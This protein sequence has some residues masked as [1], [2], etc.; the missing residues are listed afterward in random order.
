MMDAK[1]TTTQLDRFVT[2]RGAGCSL[3]VIAA[4]PGL[5]GQVPEEPAQASSAQVRP[6]AGMSA[7]MAATCQAMMH[8]GMM[9]HMMEHMQ[10]GKNSMEMCPMMKHPGSVKH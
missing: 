1:E 9:A 8:H 4:T 6:H 3:L 7:D 10:A 2:G 5:A